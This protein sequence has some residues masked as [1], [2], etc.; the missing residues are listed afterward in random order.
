MT[1]RTPSWRLMVLPPQKVR[2]TI[3]RANVIES[4]KAVYQP[5]PRMASGL[6][7]TCPPPLSRSDAAQPRA[8][9]ARP[10][11]PHRARLKATALPE[12]DTK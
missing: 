3:G 2:D 12:K 9:F 4:I 5:D 6:A 1:R 10:D 7:G 8:G 11:G